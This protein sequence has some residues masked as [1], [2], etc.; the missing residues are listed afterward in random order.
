MT[1]KRYEVSR[2]PAALLPLLLLG[3]P[4][5]SASAEPTEVERLY[6]T[7]EDR[8]D[9]GDFAG[10]VEAWT[11]LLELL[12]EEEANRAA[13]ATMV[14]RIADAH[15]RTY[16]QVPGADG[17]RDP[18][19]LHRARTLLDDYERTLRETYGASAPIPDRIE[20]MR[21]D[22]DERLAAFDPE[23]V[24][25]CLQ[26]CLAPPCLAPCLSPIEPRGCG[27]KQPAAAFVVLGALGLGIRRRRDALVAVEG[28]LPADVVARLRTRLDRDDLQ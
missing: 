22:I 15:V 14:L 26:P 19:H 27:G 13:R 18:A 16:D 1:R 4:S 3:V 21:R 24:G 12:P 8:Y 28:A 25:P 17:N 2:L 5:G 7:G 23:D 10:A 20:S 6:G 9:R 11:E